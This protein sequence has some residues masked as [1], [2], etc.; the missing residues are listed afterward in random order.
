MVP[1]DQT[2]LTAHSGPSRRALAITAA[3]AAVFLFGGGWLLL[4]Q[5]G[6]RPPLAEDVAYESGFVHGS[7][8]RQYDRVGDQVADLRAGGC[9]R[10]ALV[11]A[12][13][14]EMSYDPGLWVKGCMDGVSGRPAA[15]QGILG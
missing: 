8:V 12:G 1:P 13:G 3:I 14:R 2:S 6:D 10:L 15:G 11:G 9:E 7:R 4:R 5:Y